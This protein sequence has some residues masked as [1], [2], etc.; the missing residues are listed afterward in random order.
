M[1]TPPSTLRA[2]TGLAAVALF[3]QAFAGC[4]GN[5]PSLPAASALAAAA[6]S[7]PANSALTLS[8]PFQSHNVHVYASKS[9]KS[10]IRPDAKTASQLLYVSDAKADVVDIFS[11]PSLT[12]LGTITG[13]GLPAGLC[14]DKKGDVYVVDYYASKI[15]EYAHGS[16]ALIATLSANYAPIGCSVNLKTGS[17]AAGTQGTASQTG[18]V[19]IFAHG[20]GT[21]TSYTAPNLAEVYFPAYDNSGNL[22]VDGAGGSSAGLAELPN[23]G[24]KFEQIT[25]DQTIVYP[26]GV[27]NDGEYLAV[28]DEYANAIYQFTLSGTNATKVGTTSLNDADDN[29]FQF[30]I[31]GTTKGQGNQV[32]GT[33][34]QSADVWNYPAGGNPT[35][36]IPGFQDAL[37]AAISQK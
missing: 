32:V 8:G 11:W 23:G 24:S 33:T 27:Q 13:F 26:A 4:S 25:M 18:G 10:W 15:D 17:L 1:K 22:F 28:G 35:A 6:P 20:R 14:V 37:A 31:T 5:S 2:A 30:W 7:V 9:R 29:L 12:Q 34:D 21:P 19:L 16:V 3:A 36:S